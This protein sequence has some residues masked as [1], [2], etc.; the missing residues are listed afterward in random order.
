MKKLS[1]IGSILLRYPPIKFTSDPVTNRK[2]FTKKK[3]KFHIQGDLLNVNADELI[4]MI[5]E[6][7]WFPFDLFKLWLIK[8]WQIHFSDIRLYWCSVRFTYS[9]GYFSERS[10]NVKMTLNVSSKVWQS[11]RNLFLSIIRYWSFFR[12]RISFHRVLLCT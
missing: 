6:H 4:S 9:G 8:F 1:T 3:N 5:L 10:H 2:Q 12:G 7:S 11:Q